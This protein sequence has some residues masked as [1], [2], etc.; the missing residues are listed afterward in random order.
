MACIQ[1]FCVP[2][3]TPEFAAVCAEGDSSSNSS[4]QAGALNISG[5]SA[6]AVT[7]KT[8]SVQVNNGSSRSIAPGASVPT[9]WGSRSPLQIASS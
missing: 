7:A 5:S 3:E 4:A 8:S 2:V 9:S 1:G 6:Q